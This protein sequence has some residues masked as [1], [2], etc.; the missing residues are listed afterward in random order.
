MGASG[1]AR[2]GGQPPSRDVEIFEH[3][4]ERARQLGDLAAPSDVERARLA[5]SDLSRFARQ[6]RERSADAPREEHREQER[7]PRGRH[8]GDEHG[9]VDVRQRVVEL[10][11]RLRHDDR[12]AGADR[13][14]EGAGRL[15]DVDAADRGGAR[16]DAE[17]Q[18]LAIWS[19]ESQR[20]P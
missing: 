6:L 19:V 1:D 17:L 3:A 11:L 2:G 5:G 8:A 14:R 13:V 12:Q 4:I 7:E 16:D 18:C 15:R 20:Q 9:V 10:A